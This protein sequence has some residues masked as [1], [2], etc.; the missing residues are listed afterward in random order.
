MV[1]FLVFGDYEEP[2]EEL[3]ESYLSI[4]EG[5]SVCDSWPMHD[6]AVVSKPEV[7][8][9]MSSETDS[10][11]EYCVNEGSGEECQ[12]VTV[13]SYLPHD[14]EKQN[15]AEEECACLKW[16]PWKCLRLCTG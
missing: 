12:K 7:G 8:K 15:S 3:T 5:M 2:Q 16:D 11:N 13:D 14:W 10:H 6:G 9:S 4:K 1:L